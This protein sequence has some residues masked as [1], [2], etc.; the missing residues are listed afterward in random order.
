M[1]LPT[2]DSQCDSGSQKDL[3][4]WSLGFNQSRSSQSSKFVHARSAPTSSTSVEG[5]RQNSSVGCARSTPHRCVPVVRRPCRGCHSPSRPLGRDQFVN[6]LN[7]E[8]RR[9]IGGAQHAEPLGQAIERGGFPLTAT[10]NPQP[11]TSP[12]RG[13]NLSVPCQLR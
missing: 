1:V 13:Y 9:L 4:V 3:S 12:D 8:D 11:I 6:V 2:Q 10:R 7:A 5:S